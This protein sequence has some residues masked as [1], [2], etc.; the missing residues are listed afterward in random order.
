MFIGLSV[1]TALLVAV[2]YVEFVYLLPG[3]PLRAMLTDAISLK[4]LPPYSI[5]LQ[6][7]LLPACVAL[8]VLSLLTL[9]VA[10]AALKRKNW[11]RIA[12]AWIMIATALAH[13]AGVILPFYLAR[14]VTAMLNNMPPDIRSFAGTMMKIVS[15]M[16]MVMGIIFGVA[17]AWIAK[18]FFSAEVAR[19]FVPDNQR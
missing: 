2:L 7:Y 4:L 15:F 1:L 5:R 12:F 9:V 11:G 17:F 14:D 10:L 18:R 19:E 8:F 16:S 3:E 6:D 13:L